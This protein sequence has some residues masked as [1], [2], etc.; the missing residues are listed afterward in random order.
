MRRLHGLPCEGRGVKPLSLA[1]AGR[2]AG[3][4]RACA[5]PRA[6]F[7]LG[8]H[9]EAMARLEAELDAAG[10][11]VTPARSAPRPFAYADISKLPW[12]DTCV[13]AR[14][15]R[16]PKALAG[17]SSAT[18]T[19]CS[20]RDSGHAVVRGR[21]PDARAGGP[22]VERAVRLSGSWCGRCMS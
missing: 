18:S 3:V 2:G 7:L 5:A 10:L 16:P 20:W 21:P 9:P 13:K 8:K 1:A 19:C 11:L 12:L 15:R 22:A 14:A 4:T 17:P 6:V